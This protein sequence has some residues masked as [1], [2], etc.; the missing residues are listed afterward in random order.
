MKKLTAED[1][2]KIKRSGPARFFIQSEQDGMLKVTFDSDICITTK[3]DE[4]I[5]G[6][7]WTKDWDKAEAKVFING[8]PKIYSLGNIKYS[9]LREFIG[10]CELN[11][12]TPDTLPGSTFEIQKTGPFN[13]TIKYIGRD[14]PVSTDIPQV[15]ISAAIKEVIADLKS[16]S[17]D[18]VK[19]GL[20]V[21]DFVKACHVRGH[22]KESDITVIL[23]LLEES[24][25][26]KIT[27]G[28]VFLL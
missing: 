16:N 20:T 5:V 9:F 4:D 6:R 11:G 15:N 22:L 23:P 10:A 14:K 19:K 18:L 12:I 2:G 27:D 28:K 13:Q 21:S 1:W 25:I 3:D 17:P 26:I 24:S 8:E 7:V